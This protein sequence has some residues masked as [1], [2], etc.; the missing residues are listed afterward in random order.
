MLP[1]LAGAAQMCESG[2]PAA[3]IWHLLS[4]GMTLIIAST[5]A[6]GLIGKDGPHRILK[7]CFGNMNFVFRSKVTLLGFWKYMFGILLTVCSEVLLFRHLSYS[8]HT[9]YAE[10]NDFTDDK[11]IT[12]DFGS[13]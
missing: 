7:I 5:L 6:F 13:S 10:S 3:G 8:P 12:F 9:V 4:L 2:N 11:K 1:D